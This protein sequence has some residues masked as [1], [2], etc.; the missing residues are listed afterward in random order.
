MR[1]GEHEQFRN[2]EIIISKLFPE[3]V[4]GVCLACII[5]I[6]SWMGYK[7]FWIGFGE[8]LRIKLVAR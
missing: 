3:F 1:A 6:V 2:S 4:V 8:L 7:I 5:L